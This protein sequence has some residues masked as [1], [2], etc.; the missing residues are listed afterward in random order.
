M[1]T[2][3]GRPDFA[4]LIRDIAGGD[5]HAL[6]VLHDAM[7]PSLYTTLATVFDSATAADL[8]ERI[9]IQI[10]KQADRFEPTEQDATEWLRLIVRSALR[11]AV[12]A[13]GLPN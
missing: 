6:Q 4:H 7:A 3:P 12:I 10:W 13:R 1:P 2:T 11:D 9:F 5:R 8:L